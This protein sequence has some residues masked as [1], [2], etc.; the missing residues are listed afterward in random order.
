MSD[1]RR[2]FVYYA[3]VMCCK[4]FPDWSDFF[5]HGR[6]TPDRSHGYGSECRKYRTLSVRMETTQIGHKNIMGARQR[7][8]DVM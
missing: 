1:S 6:A 8:K 7:G 5:L 2:H 4:L 3:A